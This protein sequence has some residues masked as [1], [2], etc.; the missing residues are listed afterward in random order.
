MLCDVCLVHACTF[1]HCV[2]THQERKHKKRDT[3]FSPPISESRISWDIS[4]YTRVIF[5]L[6]LKQLTVSIFC[7]TKRV[8]YVTLPH[9]SLIRTKTRRRSTSCMCIWAKKVRRAHQKFRETQSMRD[10][11]Q[12]AAFDHCQSLRKITT[13]DKIT[14]ESL[15]QRRVSENDIRKF[16]V[17]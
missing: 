8:A 4:S 12:T 14:Q 9:A 10:T 17:L 1:D 2:N 5:C 13:K 7:R 16:H 3:N 15:E 6:G 11:N